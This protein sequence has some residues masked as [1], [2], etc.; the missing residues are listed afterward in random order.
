MLQRIFALR[1]TPD[2]ETDWKDVQ[3]LEQYQSFEKRLPQD[4]KECLPVEQGFDGFHD[5]LD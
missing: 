2:L 5:L 1:G 3:R 4:W